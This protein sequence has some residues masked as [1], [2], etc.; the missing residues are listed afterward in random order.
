MVY[1]TVFAEFNCHVNFSVLKVL[2][3]VKEVGVILYII[4][5]VNFQTCIDV[6]ISG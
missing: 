4:S 3:M 6:H 5:T 1:H 2:V